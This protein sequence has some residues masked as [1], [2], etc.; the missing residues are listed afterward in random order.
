MEIRFYTKDIQ[1]FILSLDDRSS[2][3]IDRLITLLRL[4][5]NE[6][7]MPYSKSLKNGLF[8]LRKISRKQIRII[9]CFHRNEAIILHI[10]E[11]KQNT[12]SKKDLLLAKQRRDSLA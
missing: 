1:K 8:E 5:G 6:I 2:A 3:D 10:F 11:K 9:Y 7:K 4:C 12:I